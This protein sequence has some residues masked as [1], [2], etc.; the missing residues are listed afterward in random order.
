MKESNVSIWF[1][2]L[3]GI[4]RFL[5]NLLL[6]LTIFWVDR[7]TPPEFNM[8]LFYLLPLFIAVWYENNI[9]PGIFLSML[10]TAAYYFDDLSRSSFY[11]TGI[12]LFWELFAAFG[13]FFV[14]I[15]IVF[16]IKKDKEVLQQSESKF[17]SLF[18][19]AEVGMF[20]ARADGSEMIDCNDTY[21]R[22]FNYSRE[23]IEGKPTV[24][25][26]ADKDERD[27]LINMIKT[28]GY[29]KDY[30]CNLMNKQGKLIRCII[31]LRL[32]RNSGIHEGS[33]V[34]ITAL[35]R[36]EDELRESQKKFKQLVW[37]MQVGVLLQGPK[38]E[39]LLSNP[40]A[41]ELLGLSEDQLLGKTSFDPDWNVT[42]AD[43]SP[44][45]GNTHP[46]P[47][48]IATRHPVKGVVMGVYHHLKNDRVWLLVDAEPQ[49]DGEGVVKQV[50]CT[51]VDITERISAESLIQKQNIQLQE[52]N[53]TK[54][55]FFSI[56]AHDLRSP[57]HGFLGLT[58]EIIRSSDSISVQ[59]LKRI[60]NTMYQAADNLFRLLQNLLEWA[61]MQ[62]GSMTVGMKDVL[63]T[64]MIAENVVE[65]NARCLL[66]EISIINMVSEQFHAYADEKMVNSVL[67]NLLS[68][69]VKFTKR[70]GTITVSTMA[71]EDQMIEVSIKDTGIGI[72]DSMLDKVFIL[73]EKT[74][75]KGTDGEM[76]SGLGLLLC[77]EFV[78]K[79]GGKIWLESEEGVGSNFHFTLKSRQ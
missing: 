41:L 15:F 51:F 28:A 48:A 61:Q 11:A 54:N 66:K 68:N 13:F 42:H 30:E 21:L 43:G 39:F 34:D 55:K 33:L 23:E 31:S 45:P 46:V 2:N 38:A 65:I 75:R 35:K 8:R 25:F 22:I 58:Q 49:L 14:F 36:A 53:T 59:D 5:L 78:E 18:N 64:N 71:I 1:K 69:A 6:I 19:N 9:I 16:R 74:S 7:L 10:F 63:L 60:G 47:L 26:W 32:D 52:L 44:F 29:A 27:K 40:K 50:V 56:I 17:R 67:L 76:S 77:K 24:D 72:P 70:K 20:R 12:F 4:N 3:A 79:N 73:G 37:D 57:F 62:S